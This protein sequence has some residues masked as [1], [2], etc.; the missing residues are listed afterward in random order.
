MVV[1]ERVE[2]RDS[3]ASVAI[4]NNIRSEPCECEGGGL[5]L[6][7]DT[8]IA[9]YWHYIYSGRGC[10]VEGVI[11]GD[12]QT[13]HVTAGNNGFGHLFGES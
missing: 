8:L 4:L 13:R 12:Q 6:E 5:I 2:E 10:R 11:I 9:E 7:F 3:T 1:V